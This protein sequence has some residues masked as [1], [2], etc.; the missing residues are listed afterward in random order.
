MTP[1]TVKNKITG[2]S[3]AVPCGRCPACY[4]RRVSQWSFR[5]MQEDKVSTT[6]HFITLT[7]DTE[8][9][10]ITG[11][12]F[13]S[14]DKRHLQLFFKRLRKSHYMAEPGGKPLKYFAVGEYGGKYSRPHYHIILFNAKLKL[15][16]SESDF[17]VLSSAKLDGKVPVKS[18]QWEYG[19]MTVGTVSGASI[20][21]SL[22]Y[23]SKTS[24]IPIHKNDDRLKEFALM[25][26]GL[27]ANYI[28]PQMIRWHHKDKTNRMYCNLTDGKKIGMPR[29]YKEK[30]YHEAQRKAIGIQLRTKML[31]QQYEDEK[32]QNYHRD[33]F[34][35]AKAAFRLM[36][37]QSKK[38]QSL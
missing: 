37:I 3:Q 15:M 2:Q 27:G 35:A 6:S 34:E 30:I 4:K 36:N 28:T 18:L 5:L 11:K 23:M 12:H 20:G 26:K 38:N 10:P 14:I 29:Y 7:Y 24:K 31:K 9:V 33:K 21:Y 16:L 1:F 22:K 19:H 17:R 8:Y 32:K 13:M 25:S